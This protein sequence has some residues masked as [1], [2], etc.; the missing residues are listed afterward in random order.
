MSEHLL[1]LWRI[2]NHTLVSN[3]NN[4][5]DFWWRK[6]LYTSDKQEGELFTI[7]AQYLHKARWELHAIT[8]ASLPWDRIYW[9][10]SLYSWQWCLPT[11]VGPARGTWGRLTNNYGQYFRH[12]NL[13]KN[14][15]TLTLCKQY[16]SSLPK[17]ITEYLSLTMDTYR[18][19]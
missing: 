10:M 1:S 7:L 17:I 3:N 12:L 6:F 9:L 11:Q 2:I 19:Y 18:Q 14:I 13:T 16:Y 5:K 4:S 8:A 15:Y